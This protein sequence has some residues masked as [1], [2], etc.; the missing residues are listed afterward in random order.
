MNPVD[1]YIAAAPPDR[2]EA[3]KKLRNILRDTLVP[4][5]YEEGISYKMIGYSVPYSTYPEGYH[6]TPKVPLPFINLANQ[7]GGIHL[8]HMGVTAD[9]DLL[10]WWQDEY[11]KLGIGKLDMGVGCIRFK[12]IKKIPYDL[13]CTLVSKVTPTEWVALYEAR[14]RNKK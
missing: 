12:N 5:G 14:Y 2:Q 4:M 6:C 11:A 13:I 3:L 1:D 7:K 10:A 8:Y 9:S